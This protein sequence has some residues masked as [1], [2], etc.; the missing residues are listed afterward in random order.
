MQALNDDALSQL[1]PETRLGSVGSAS[2]VADA[3]LEEFSVTAKLDVDRGPTV[4]SGVGDQLV[5]DYPKVLGAGWVEPQVDC[6]NSRLWRDSAGQ[7]LE[8]RPGIDLLPR[9]S[10]SSRWTSAI[11]WIR[12]A[13]SSNALPESPVGRPK[14]R[15]SAT[16]CKLFFTRW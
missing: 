5:G 4:F 2:A 14:R 1:Q 3:E 7:D 9:C 16:V 13:V 12:L 8:Q 6:L 10:A 11:A 15:R